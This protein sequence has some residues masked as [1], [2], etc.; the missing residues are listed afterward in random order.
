MPLN[1][2][3]LRRWFAAGAILVAVVVACAYWYARWKFRHVAQEIPKKMN[4][5]VQQTAQGFTISKSEEGHTIFT[6]RASNAV[7]YKQGG[8]AEL[9]DVSITIYGK[10]AQRFDQIY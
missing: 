3:R 8:R 10:D 1:I 5:S 6:I 7:Q 9:H 2:P 4:I